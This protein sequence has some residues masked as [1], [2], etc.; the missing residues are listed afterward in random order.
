[1][2]GT[3]IKD[4]IRNIA[5]SIG[6]DIVGFTTAEAFDAKP[7]Y[8]RSASGYLS[9]LEEKDIN[10]RTIPRL[11]FDT[12]RSIIALGLSY[13]IPAKYF[14]K[15]GYAFISRSAYGEDYHRVMSD[16]MLKL[17]K[18]IEKRYN[19]KSIYMVDTGPLVDRMVAQRA[20]IGWYGKNCNIIN[21]EYGSW[22]FLGEVLTELELPP[23]SPVETRCG[24]C[25]LCLKACPTGA[26]V[27]PYV[28]N[29]NKCLSYNTVKKGILPDE[30]KDK[31]GMRVYGCDTCQE[32]CPVNKR[33]KYSN[34]KEFF[35]QSPMPMI[36]LE[37]V[38]KM[39]K[40]AFER[41]FKR[42]SAGW[43]GRTVL[44]RNGIIAMGNT[45]DEK[46]IEI[47]KTFLDD[48]RP[49]ISDAA[50]WAL[51]KIERKARGKVDGF[52]SS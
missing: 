42:T 36:L 51:K 3:Y 2:E 29:A 50:K 19:V 18:Y 37:D 41:L 33:A 20:G 43:R 47:L 6:F 49:G 12:A 40:K 23:D 17:V 21:D 28:L 4:E 46:Y 9:G 26:L 39:D 13:N 52:K 10:K 15:A 11:S 5:Y 48:T 44:Q 34:R 8:D 25:D 24:D 14:S 45:G 38:V 30:I 7:L 1:M 27:S 16:M 22:I 31:M 35:P 32:V